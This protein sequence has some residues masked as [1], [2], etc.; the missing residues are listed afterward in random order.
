MNRDFLEDYEAEEKE[1]WYSFRNRIREG[2]ILSDEKYPPKKCL[3][4]QEPYTLNIPHTKIWHKI[5]LYG[6]TI[7]ALVPAKGKD[8][9]EK[10]NGF[11][12]EDLDRLMDFA[13]DTGRIAFGLSKLPTFFKE[14]EY[15]EPLFEELRP[16][17]LCT[18][19][20]KEFLGGKE[21]DWWNEI[22]YI[23]STS[24]V[25]MILKRC[26]DVGGV[27]LPVEEYLKSFLDSY[28]LLRAL[29]FDSLADEMI[30]R[31]SSDPVGAIIFYWGIESYLLTPYRSVLG[32]IPSITRDRA[33]LYKK[34][35]MS[36]FPEE[37]IK[38]DI[39]FPHEIGL[40][41]A[42]KL[43]LITPKNLEGSIELSDEFKANDLR[44]VMIALNAAIDNEQI[45]HVKARTSDISEIIDN[46]WKEADKFKDNRNFLR[47]GL[48]FGVAVVGAIATMP[49]GGIGGLLA[50]L[51]F[52][53]VEEIFD[54]K[55]SNSLSEN[56]LK[57]VHQNHMIH[58]YDFKKK[59]Q[60]S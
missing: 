33:E 16:P 40:F 28:C 37:T 3:S 32:E 7:I 54:S 4:L 18:K 26:I 52:E 48:S 22:N 2:K 6:T 55:F 47:H 12:V 59:Y 49:I 60:L 29:G 45:D 9:F 56:I 25:P 10:L 44:K 23:V 13:K 8:E 51:G 19:T 57:T 41:L 46:V 1:R 24:K 17:S 21:N 35:L 20:Y 11:D 34:K 14:Q 36:F 38:N 50:G 58:L 27:G 43:R 30:V 5:P 53:V 42:D 15:L 39:E 31:V